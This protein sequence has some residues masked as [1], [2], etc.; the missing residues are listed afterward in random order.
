MTLIV[1]EVM[2]REPNL[3]VPRKKPVGPVKIDWSHSLA[4]GLKF[5]VAPTTSAFE[6]TEYNPPVV[7][8]DMFI[9]VGE[10]GLCY[11]GSNSANSDYYS[12]QANGLRH[13]YVDLSIFSVMKST[14]SFENYSTIV[15]RNYDGSTVPFVFNLKENVTSIGGFSWYNGGWDNLRSTAWEALAGDSKI[16][17]LAGTYKASPK[18]RKLYIDGVFDTSDV[19]SI[20]LP[21]GNTLPIDVGNYIFAGDN[22][23][24]GDIYC[25]YI[26]NR[27][28]SSS[29]VASLSADPYQFLIP[30]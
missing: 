4:N 17:S 1:D 6:L 15:S 30:A 21:T 20:A 18:S 9:G 13:D 12:Y 29:E 24:Y 16:H 11:T 28:L 8:G 22:R 7:S 19:P 3:L 27:N 5:C 25:V 14:A 10:G 26:F 2:L 23:F